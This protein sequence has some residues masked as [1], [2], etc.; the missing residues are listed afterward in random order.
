V[1][2]DTASREMLV[3]GARRVR[4]C[5]R[6]YPGGTVVHA[7]AIP[8]YIDQRKALASIRTLPQEWRCSDQLTSETS[9]DRPRQ[10]DSG[11]P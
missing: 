4:R 10:L 8:A 1:N 3:P 11:S 9:G 5:G 2:P 7:S 6:M